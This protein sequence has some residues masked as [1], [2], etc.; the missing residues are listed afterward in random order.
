M[1]DLL[2]DFCYRVS[3]YIWRLGMRLRNIELKRQAKKPMEIV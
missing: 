1:F 3:G 2:A